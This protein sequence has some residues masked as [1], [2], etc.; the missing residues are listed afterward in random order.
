LIPAADAGRIWPDQKAAAET[1]K[2]EPVKEALI[3]VVVGGL[4][5]GF[6]AGQIGASQD[7]LPPRVEVPR[8]SQ[9]A[10]VSEIGRFQVVNG[11]PQYAMNIM[12][13]DTV[14]GDTW[15]KCGSPE[16]SDTWCKVNRTDSETSP[17]KSGAPN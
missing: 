4:V 10:P 17:K 7:T 12:L 11:T 13:L 8:P 6:T 15:I 14:T 5:A 3:G 16:T 1:A 2:G 9:P